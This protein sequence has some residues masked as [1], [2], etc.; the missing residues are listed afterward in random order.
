M[1]GAGP[2]TELLAFTSASGCR[3]W[4]AN[5]PLAESQQLQALLLRQLNLLADT[6]L[7]PGE[8]AEI[9]ELLR[10]T[11]VLAQTSCSRRFAGKLLPLAEAE[12]AAYQASLALWLALEAN[13]LLCLQENGQLPERTALIAQRA[14]SA[15]T[16]ARQ[17]DCRAGFLPSASYWRRLH[18][19]YRAAESLQLTHRP[20]ADKLRGHASTNVAAAYVEPLLIAAAQPF[21][22]TPRQLDLVARWAQR[23]SGKVLILAV[24]PP[25]APPGT[26]PNVPL[27][28]VDLAGEQPVLFKPIRN[29]G[30]LLR[31]LDPAKLRKSLKVRLA[32][33]ADGVSPELLQLGKDCVQ[34]ACAE[35]LKQVYLIWCKGG[36]LTPRRTSRNAS[37]QLVGGI[38][39]IHY[40]LSGE[41]F[42]QPAGPARLNKQELDEIATF[43]SIAARRRD[44]DGEQYALEVWQLAEE[45]SAGLR[46]VRPLSQPGMRLG[47]G[48]LVAVH[49]DGAQGFLL[50]IVRAV[51]VDTDAG[52]VA[53]LLRFLPGKPTA[54]A[55]RGTG[56]TAANEMFRPGLRLPAVPQLNEPASVLMPSGCFRPGRIVETY[57][58]HSRTIR[59]SHLL[60]RGADFERADF[61][62]Q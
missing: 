7:P 40:Q 61:E 62:W 48:H 44:G 12:Q 55:L 19:I 4:L 43:G 51:M 53:A 39:A 50:G 45:D 23:W 36:P 47:N 49:S 15:M 34:P 60:E 32:A 1:I 57:S 41:A 2:G 13:Y 46:L 11:I 8:R 35:L 9:L 22:L 33:L 17:D 56:V 58:D 24:A 30:A 31:W 16:W 10:E 38:A 42:R 37:C 14:L 21:E 27:L 54:V 25:D 6:A 20:V 26:R 52:C 28:T 59:L 18:G 29:D 3:A 5:L